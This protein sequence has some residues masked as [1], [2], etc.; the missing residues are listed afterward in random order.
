MEA[1]CR[2]HQLKLLFT[3]ANFTLSFSKM[4]ETM[5]NNEFFYQGIKALESNLS[6]ALQGIYARYP[7]FH[8][9]SFD[10]KCLTIW[11]FF[12]ILPPVL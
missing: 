4:M 7:Y 6:S 8:D 3:A 10:L 12:I 2:Q 9:G 11:S 5:L 1:V